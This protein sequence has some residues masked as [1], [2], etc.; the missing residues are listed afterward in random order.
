MLT[1]DDEMTAFQR[2]VDENRFREEWN[3]R[4]YNRKLNR[5]REGKPDVVVEHRHVFLS[6][7][8]TVAMLIGAAV[9]LLAWITVMGGNA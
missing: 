8:A 5:R 3:I 1:P 7:R 9:V 2:I 4:R 6:N